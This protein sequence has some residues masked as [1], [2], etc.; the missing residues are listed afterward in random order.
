MRSHSALY[1]LPDLTQ[2]HS[3]P[4]CCWGFSSF[5][6]SASPQ[7]LIGSSSRHQPLFLSPSMPSSSD[8]VADL[9]S[10]GVGCEVAGPGGELG[11]ECFDRCFGAGVDE[12]DIAV[13]AVRGRHEALFPVLEEHAIAGIHALDLPS[14]AGPCHRP[15]ACKTPGRC[16]DLSRRDGVSAWRARR[17]SAQ[18]HRRR[19]SGASS[20]KMST[21]S[22]S[23]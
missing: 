11:V 3:D 4:I 1:D 9:E 23:I 12:D 21:P 6:K 10:H 19:G 17:R 18:G 16:R 22:S 14:H 2:T 5:A 20:R 15:R 13:A 8:W 7:S